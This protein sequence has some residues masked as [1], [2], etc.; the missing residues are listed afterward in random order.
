MQSEHE[1]FETPVA[2]RPDSTTSMV[3]QDPDPVPPQPRF[4]GTFSAS[5]L[6]PFDAEASL[7]SQMATVPTLGLLQQ[8]IVN[9]G[10]PHTAIADPAT[11]VALELLVAFLAQ[12]QDAPLPPDESIA[13]VP[14]SR[15]TAL[16]LAAQCTLDRI[17]LT[18]APPPEPPAR[19]TASPGPSHPKNPLSKDWA[20]NGTHCAAL[21]RD[22]VPVQFWLARLINEL[23]GQGFTCDAHGVTQGFFMRQLLR[24]PLSEQLCP[25][26]ELLPEVRAEVASGTAPLRRRAVPSTTR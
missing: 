8:C 7:R 19:S 11:E 3:A 9:V 14:A 23:E 1:V 6:Q 20:F 12:A 13:C 25:K 21:G 16:R 10:G 17:R 26:I 5:N 2:R 4:T 15:Y 18:F 24:S 22:A